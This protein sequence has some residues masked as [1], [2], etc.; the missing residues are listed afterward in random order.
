MR[1][2]IQSFWINGARL[3]PVLCQLQQFPQCD[4]SGFLLSFTPLDK[5]GSDVQLLLFGLHLLLALHPP[6]LRL[7]L[8]PHPLGLQQPPLRFQLL[9]VLHP[10]G[11]HML[12][13]LRPPA[14]RPRRRPHRCVVPR[15]GRSR[16]P[17]CPTAASGAPAEAARR[18]P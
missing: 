2:L 1:F 4:Q 8:A 18:T 10:L 5:S 11:L 7:L 16:A 13:V 12:L 14:I 17:S 9:L 3:S 15:S 6:G